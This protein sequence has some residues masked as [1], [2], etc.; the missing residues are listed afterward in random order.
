VVDY[1]GDGKLDI[2]VGDFRTN[3]HIKKGLTPKQ[4]KEF[5][6][7][8]DR[9]VRAVKRFNDSVDAI[10]ARWKKRLQEF[11]KSEWLSPKYK[12]LLKKMSKEMEDSP[13]Y[14]K[15]VTGSERYEKDL[16]Q[17]VDAGT[18]VSSPAMAHGYVWF[19]RRK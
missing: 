13:E 2:L 6:E 5:K 11:P 16:R 4:R 7:M 9:Q 8:R 18:G 14:K 15:Y 10:R 1:D 3:L 12:A 19:F 17:Y